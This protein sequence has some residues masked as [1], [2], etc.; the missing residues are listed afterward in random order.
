MSAKNTCILVSLLLL[1]SL[2]HAQSIYFFKTTETLNHEKKEAL[3]SSKT[4]VYGS[5]RQELSSRKKKADRIEELN[6]EL[7]QKLKVEDYLGAESIKAE[8]EQI[9]QDQTKLSELRNG[10]ESSLS[11]EDYEKAAEYKSTL[12]TEY[13]RLSKQAESRRLAEEAEAKRLAE[14]ARAKRLA[15]EAE[16]QR[17]IQKLEA[18]LNQKLEVEDYLAA[19]SIKNEL[20]T[21]KANDLNGNSE[22][23]AA[24]QAENDKAALLVEQKR[25]EDE[26]LKRQLA[27][28]KA[29]E[30]QLA[31]K[32][33]REEEAK[34]LRESEDKRLAEELAEKKAEEERKAAELEAKLAEERRRAAELE[35]KLAEEK[36]KADKL[37]AKL[38]DEERIRLEKIAAEE[39][40]R[41]RKIAEEEARKLEEQKRRELAKQLEEEARKERQARFENLPYFNE[42]VSESVYSENFDGGRVDFSV[43]TVEDRWKGPNNGAYESRQY[44]YEHPGFS[45]TTLN[46]N[47]DQEKN[48]SISSNVLFISGDTKNPMG[49]IWG[50]KGN[51]FFLFGFNK[52]GTVTISEYEGGRL[53]KKHFSEAKFPAVKDNWTNVLKVAKIGS[54]WVFVL[55]DKEFHRMPY[56]GVYGVNSGFVL[57]N[58]A[59]AR[60]DNFKINYITK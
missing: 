1:S 43:S 15:A 27:D 6:E 21:L 58:N 60:F 28:R 9:K 5:I 52:K 48:Y 16:R 30:E 38:A 51:S 20:E 40:E 12:L 46:V 24:P 41:Q 49:I 54:E 33:R 14:E 8:L 35:A 56:K 50:A 47:I 29:K 42:V 3:A 53:R 45:Y 39:A 18:D 7:N 32:K 10:I 13:Q 36:R 37:A 55:N 23:S 17:K 4:E 31:E 44:G 34:K 22:S 26:K 2:A 11:T 19:E 57:P 25:L 59:T